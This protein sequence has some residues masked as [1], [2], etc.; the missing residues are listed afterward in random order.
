MATRRKSIRMSPEDD[1]S[2]RRLY[3]EFGVPSDQYAKRPGDLARFIRRWNEI[4]DRGDLAEDD[5]HIKT[6]RK[7]R[8][9]VTF[10]GE[11]E[12]APPPENLTPEQW[13]ELDA[14]YE[15]KCVP[16]LGSDNIDYDAELANELARNLPNGLG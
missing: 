7:N 11:H 4:S 12:K 15:A 1:N 9:W 14:A 5:R 10:G 3:L 13:V 16:G 6:K 8:R 2:L